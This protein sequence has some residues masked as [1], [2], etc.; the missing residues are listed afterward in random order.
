MLTIQIR[1]RNG[2]D[3]TRQ[4]HGTEIVIG[5]R[6]DAP[7]DLDLSPDV[8]VSRPHARLWYDCST[9][10]VE[11]LG[12]R[13]GTLLQGI[14]VASPTPLSPGDALKLGDTVLRVQFT[15]A[16]TLHPPGMVESRVAVAETELP[17]AISEDQGLRLWTQVA[18]ISA[19][20]TGQTMLNG[21]LQV[22]ISAFP[23]AERAT[24]LTREGRE[25]VSRASSPPG[26]SRF[27]FTLAQRALA[28]EQ[29]FRWVRAQSPAYAE[30]LTGVMTALCA[31]MLK[32]MRVV[33]VLHVDATTPGVTFSDDDL[34][35]LALLANTLGATIEESDA[36]T[37][38]R[39]PSAFLSYADDESERPFAQR[40]AADLRRRS[41]KVVTHES[42]DAGAD[43]RDHLKVAIKS[44]DAFVLILSP[45]AIASEQIAWEL[46]RARRAQRPI[47]PLVYD[48]FD[49]PAE[50]QQFKMLYVDADNYRPGLAD[51]VERLHLVPRSVDSS[52]EEAEP[53]RIL[54]LAANP[55]STTRLRLD[56][57]VRTIDER[58][59]SA[60]FRARFRLV[61]HWAV[62]SSDLSGY[63][64][65]YK[66]HI[67]HF[68]GH[69]CD[70]GE[71]VL[72]DRTGSIQPISPDA[73]GRL[74]RVLR[75]NVRCVVLNACYSAVQAEAIAREIDC[76][77]GMSQ[78]IGDDAAIGFA[79]GF[80]Q[81]LGY[82]RSVQT[83]FDLGC[84]EIDLA[85]IGE[86]ATPRILARPGVDAADVTFDS[87]D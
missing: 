87:E 68:S 44:T 51:L 55:V 43:R 35:R 67:V 40:L 69:G 24:I 61:S 49:V 29:A 16:G 75:D 82:G 70:G 14:P 45:L 3:Q 11:D 1:H 4:F 13:Y 15:E 66:P 63:L 21:F 6:K 37:F 56:E 36:Q 10:W 9:W 85:G 73:L 5:R 83:A 81:A 76:V 60:E 27:S 52:P 33:G 2:P 23:Q 53:M 57:E 18:T 48:R 20:S 54:F 8:T 86:E 58:L 41:V 79:S 46:R 39:L 71:I 22:L 32:K 80:Y 38:D 42:V 78:S 26:P 12:S 74:F 59:R 84:N 47:F 62:R 50:L 34:Q 7:V 30:S 19:Y 31:P 64:L 72:E 17:S 28:E 65:R 77:V 25:L